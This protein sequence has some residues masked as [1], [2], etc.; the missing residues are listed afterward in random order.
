M[1]RGCSGDECLLLSKSLQS[2]P[3]KCIKGAGEGFFSQW[4]FWE[5]EL[6]EAFLTCLKESLAVSELGSGEAVEINCR[7]IVAEVL[8]ITVMTLFPRKKEQSAHSI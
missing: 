1:Q 6:L 7:V 8:K 4:T 5:S 3:T 2:D